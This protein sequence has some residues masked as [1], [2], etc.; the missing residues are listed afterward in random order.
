MPKPHIRIPDIIGSDNSER[1]IKIA[2]ALNNFFIK[3][4]DNN[5]NPLVDSEGD[6]APAI[7]YKTLDNRKRAYILAVLW[8]LDKKAN[9]PIAWDRV[10]DELNSKMRSMLIDKGLWTIHTTETPNA[11][12]S[13]AYNAVGHSILQNLEYFHSPEFLNHL[14]D[15]TNMAN[16]INGT[17][18]RANPVSKNAAIRKKEQ[19]GNTMSV[20]DIDASI[21]DAKLQAKQ[22]KEQ[23]KNDPVIQKAKKREKHAAQLARR[24][25]RYAEHPE[26]RLAAIERARQRNEEIRRRKETDP[27]FAAEFRRK[28][29]ESK[30]RERERKKA[31]KQD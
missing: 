31:A 17:R 23:I 6:K 30:Q 10:V 15:P 12:E 9:S 16:F 27:E 1:Y 2:K 29:A 24:H 19:H 8:G 18:V 11:K 4:V 7:T 20:R 5:G 22:A 13:N 28:S 25:E 26:K 21:M 3:G 14:Y